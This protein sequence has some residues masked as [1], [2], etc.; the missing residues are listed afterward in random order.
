LIARTAERAV[1]QRCVESP[2][3]E[4]VAIYGRRRIGK[5]YLV[6]QFFGDTFAFAATG[7]ARSP[8]ADQLE[9]FHNALVDFGW[10]G[11]RPTTWLQAFRALI[12]LLRSQR[13]VAEAKKVVFLDELPW[14]DTRRS[15]FVSALEYFWNSYGSARGDLILVV[16]GSAASWMTDRIIR[17][18]GGLHNRVTVQ[19]PMEPFT[20]AETEAY[21]QSRGVVVSRSHIVDAAMVFGGVPFYLRQLDSRQGL[22]QNI[23][24]ICF[25][26]KAP[27]AHEYEDLF[28]SLFRQGGHHRAIVEAVARH[29]TGL[30]NHAILS[31]TGLSEGGTLT[32]TLTELEQSGFTTRLT[33]F[34]AGKKGSLTALTD[35]FCLFHLTF[36]AAT[37]DPAFWTRFSTTP[38]HH[39]W[40]G[41]AFEQ[42]CLAHIAQIKQALGIAGVATRESAWRSRSTGD[43][44]GAQ[45][46]LV[47]DRDDG[48]INLCEIKHA[49]AE[50]ALTADEAAALRRRTE[51]FRAQTGTRRTIHLTMITPFG[52][53]RNAYTDTVQQSLTL[54]DLFSP[55]RV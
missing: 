46:D 26:K 45:I 16:C 2:E 47:I 52:L 53:T 49:P 7:L 20:L 17:D 1:L 40:A 39:A 6:R 30:T 22:V 51:V 42:V 34:G 37:Q 12:L 24:R 31:D 41:Y 4:F 10:S 28:S 19:L 33:P 36:M 54:D 5:T 21:L 3:A 23:D 14:F 11:P 48:V 15:R 35:P 50:Y 38:R 13:P 43:L 8:M 29:P 9:A 18:H 25:A 27:L 32:K 55:T 44:P